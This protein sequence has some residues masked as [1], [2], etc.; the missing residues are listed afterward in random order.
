MEGYPTQAQESGPT[1]FGD[2]YGCPCGCGG[3]GGCAG[4][5]SRVPLWVL[6]L[7]IVFG[8]LAIAGRR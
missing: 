3:S 8:G 4:A 1:L 2:P 7:V 5:A 6:G